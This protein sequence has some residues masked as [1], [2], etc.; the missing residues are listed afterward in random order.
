[1]EPSDFLD[2]LKAEH[3]EW[4][5]L[6]NDQYLRNWENLLSSDNEAA[7][8]EAYV[9]RI[10]QQ[11]GVTVEP[12]EDLT[13]N[14]RQPDFKCQKEGYK[15]YV[16]VTCINIEKV[17]KETGLPHHLPDHKARHY[18]LL[19][20]AFW[21]A[22]KRK[23]SQC[24]NCDASVII[25]VGTF[26]YRA[27]CTCLA[28]PHVEML[29][30]GET[31]IACNLDTKKGSVVGAPYQITGLR[32]AVFLNN[33]GFARDSISALLVCGLGAEPPTILGIRHPN[34]KHSFKT[35]NIA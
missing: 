15:F 26:H 22:C 10:L 29:L 6:F 28:K 8:T 12:N 2:N 23:A 1:M 5:V 19:N 13:G 18:S 9:R 33:S 16:E 30:T 31:S 35:A 17:V 3:S 24:G 14:T 27:S 4:L 11:H 34:P 25:A 20:D 21:D 32:S 7:M